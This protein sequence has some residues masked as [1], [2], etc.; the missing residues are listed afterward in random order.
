[1]KAALNILLMIFLGLS[2]SFCSSTPKDSEEVSASDDS[3]YDDYNSSSTYDDIQGAAGSDDLS[4]GTDDYGT[5]DY[6]STGDSA[7]SATDLYLGGTEDSA[8]AD[9]GDSALPIEQIQEYKD[10]PDSDP[11]EPASNSG[12][13]DGFYNIAT[14]CNMRSEPSATAAHEGKIKAGK[15][16]WVEGY[17]DGWVKVFK[18]SGPVFISKVCL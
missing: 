2:V 11:I 14:N 4:T 17:N 12:F 18:R 3:S 1:M 5:D 6:G 7:A 16:L 9:P 8:A 10:V 15:R 13:K